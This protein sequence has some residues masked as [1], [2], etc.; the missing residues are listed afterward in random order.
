MQKNKRTI[1]AIAALTV[2]SIFLLSDGALAWDPLNGDFSIGFHV[3]ESLA[4]LFANVT[5]WFIG[6]LSGPV[7][8]I[9]GRFF[10]IGL[11]Q[12]HLLIDS[13][14]VNTV[15]GISLSVAN[16]IYLLALL[17]ASI[18]I[19]TRVNTGIYNIKKF[20]G[21][22]VIAVALSNFSLYIF[23][24][25][26]SIGGML[27]TV[28]YKIGDSLINSGAT[29]SPTIDSEFLVAFF[30]NKLQEGFI[31]YVASDTLA[32]NLVSLG[33]TLLFVWV[34]AKLSLLL[35]SRILN[36]FL[37][38]VT[39]PILFAASLLPNFQKVAQGWWETLFKW[40]LVL[41][42]SLAL[43]L[44]S[45]FFFKQA[46]LDIELAFGPNEVFIADAAVGSGGILG[47]YTTEQLLYLIV[48]FFALWNAGMVSNYLKLDGSLSGIVDTPSKAGKMVSDTVT[49]KNV[50]GKNVGRVSRAGY[51]VLQGT[52]A[53]QKIEGWRSTRTGMLGKVINPEG[54][55]SRVTAE[56][57][58]KIQTAQ[59][60]ALST[61]AKTAKRFL[62]H[63][64]QQEYGQDWDEITDGQKKQL[65]SVRNKRLGSMN[66]GLRIKAAESRLKGATG[67]IGYYAGKA[68]KETDIFTLDEPETLMADIEDEAKKGDYGKV[69]LK[70]AQLKKIQKSAMLDKDEKTTID[71]WIATTGKDIGKDSGY[72]QQLSI[73]KNTKTSKALQDTT[74]VTAVVNGADPHPDLEINAHAEQKLKDGSH[75]PG[76]LKEDLIQE[77][78]KMASHVLA[79]LSNDATQLDTWISAGRKD[80]ARASLKTMGLRGKKAKKIID[81]IEA[82][83]PEDA[84][85]QMLLGGVAKEDRKNGTKNLVN[86]VK[87]NKTMKPMDQN[88]RNSFRTTINNKL[89]GGGATI[90]TPSSPT[91]N[92]ETTHRRIA[93]ISRLWIQHVQ[94]AI[95]SNP[96]LNESSPLTALPDRG[97]ALKTALTNMGVGLNLTNKATI[98]QALSLLN[99]VI[100]SS[101]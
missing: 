5:G 75:S 30:T 42:A 95:G 10:E 4:S 97:K 94:N 93:T 101:G 81:T 56:R 62:N 41:P 89:T 67:A 49:G 9:I 73:D 21:G 76:T 88:T 47:D 52:E 77:Y 90:P 65:K 58:Q 57:K 72:K 80:L 35:I 40:V 34:M 24:A 19:M 64:A 2:V 20:L 78:S 63:H 37:S 59:L 61:S 39:A 6:V 70:L 66:V 100:R 33:G 11:G 92:T 29:S 51:D 22:F 14:A 31:P 26:L 13:P 71:T 86:L 53:G 15:W 36:L 55:K 32:L 7:G 99:N 17:V 43:I 12:T 1:L 54:E 60:G 16:G 69:N 83:G 45:M 44:L 85:I 46:G 38:A 84:R 23:R 98:G 96:L 25:I 3:G 79:Q 18:A 91:G 74:A 87:R 48:A 28:A 68:V 50:L 82:I 27:E 8:W